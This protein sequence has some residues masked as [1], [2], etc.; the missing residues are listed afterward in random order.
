MLLGRSAVPVPRSV[1]H[2]AAMAKTRTVGGAGRGQPVNRR[3]VVRC[4]RG[5]L[6]ADRRAGMGERSAACFSRLSFFFFFF[7]CFLPFWFHP[8]GA[9]REGTRV[10]TYVGTSASHGASILPD[11]LH[12]RAALCFRD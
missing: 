5:A 12:L 6:T 7:L 11:A 1:R 4:A 3:E 8:R 2:A 9:A 10:R